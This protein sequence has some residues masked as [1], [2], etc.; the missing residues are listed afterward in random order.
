[1]VQQQDQEASKK[2]INKETREKRKRQEINEEQT[3]AILF[4]FFAACEGTM[5]HNLQPGVSRKHHTNN[6]FHSSPQTEISMVNTGTEK[7][8]CKFK[9]WKWT[10]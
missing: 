6:G 10:N 4:C 7:L 5:N 1:M 2:Y 8:V 3:Q 9:F